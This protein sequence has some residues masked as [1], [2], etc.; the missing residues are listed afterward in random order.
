MKNSELIL[1][2]FII[3]DFI[4]T[5]LLVI[6]YIKNKKRINEKDTYIDELIFELSKKVMNNYENKKKR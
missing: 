5:I 4:I 2:F 1:F 6:L 3:Y